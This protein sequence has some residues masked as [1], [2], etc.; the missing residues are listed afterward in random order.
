MR[1]RVHK[2]THT[3]EPCYCQCADRSLRQTLDLVFFYKKNKAVDDHVRVHT[4][5][6]RLFNKK[7]V[8]L[9]GNERARPA[10]T[11]TMFIKQWF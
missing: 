9:G 3:V 10:L 5:L 7:F 4:N 11:S 8:P 1:A 6:I 2:N